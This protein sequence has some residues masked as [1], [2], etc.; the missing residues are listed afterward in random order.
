MARPSLADA[1]DL[2]DLVR[3]TEDGARVSTESPSLPT[4]EFV[5]VG[6]E[7]I[8]VAESSRPSQL[9]AM[10]VAT[11]LKVKP[12]PLA[13]VPVEKRSAMPPI[14]GILLVLGLV[15][16]SLYAI[17]AAPS[18]GAKPTNLQLEGRPQ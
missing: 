16:G 3:S 18:L 6:D 8:D 13:P 15:I 4:E 5:D 2:L 10:K 11:P 17:L 9:A 7:A 1:I 12:I 14:V